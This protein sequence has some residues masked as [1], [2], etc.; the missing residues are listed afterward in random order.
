MGLHKQEHKQEDNRREVSWVLD[1]THTHT[2]TRCTVGC[3]INIAVKQE[4]G[5]KS[6][7]LLKI[8]SSRL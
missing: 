4:A 7:A 2:R 3:M 1:N 8:P 5:D 6:Q